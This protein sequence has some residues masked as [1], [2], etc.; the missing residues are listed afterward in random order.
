MQLP[1]IGECYYRKIGLRSAQFDLKV[2]NPPR[3]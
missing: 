1:L 2:F 3:S